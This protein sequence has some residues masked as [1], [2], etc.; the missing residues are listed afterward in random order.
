MPSN[1]AWTSTVPCR[2]AFLVALA[3]HIVAILR[4]VRLG[5]VTPFGVVCDSGTFSPAE[6]VA[7]SIVPG[8]G[9]GGRQSQGHNDKKDETLHD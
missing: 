1:R 6:P 7:A 3:W 4:V 2:H 5:G 9:A 8:G